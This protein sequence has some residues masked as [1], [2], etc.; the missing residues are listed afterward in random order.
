MPRSIQEAIKSMTVRLP[1]TALLLAI[2]TLA[3]VPGQ[4]VEFIPSLGVSKATDANAGDG[5]FSAGLALRAPLLPLLK[6][7]GGIAYREDSYFAQSLKVRMWPVTV[8]GW[9]TP[10]P[11]LYAGGGLGWYRT[12]YDYR[13]P[14]LNK[15]WTTDKIGVHLG[16][17][18]RLPLAPTL[19][20]DF[21]GRYVFMQ[22]TSDIQLP[23]KFNP[24]YWNAS[25]GLAIQF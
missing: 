9:V 3:P 6:V 13:S 4:A 7:E 17:G 5:K 12:T 22:K 8:S 14:L 20:L 15:D 18:V 23:T 19:G 10:A 24:D 1:V 2:V 21:N 11:G 16:G 25:V